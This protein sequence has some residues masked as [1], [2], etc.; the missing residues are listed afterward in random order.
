LRIFS[1]R[2][3]ILEESSL[4]TEKMS[5]KTESAYCSLR[6]R[7]SELLIFVSA[8]AY[9]PTLLPLGVSIVVAVSVVGSVGRR[10]GGDGLCRSSAAVGGIVMG[11]SGAGHP[12]HVAGIVHG[13]SGYNEQK[14]LDLVDSQ[15][16]E[17]VRVHEKNMRDIRAQRA[18]H[19][20]AL[21]N[22][23]R[24]EKRRLHWPQ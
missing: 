14:F 21:D 20:K 15:D 13:D 5:C 16:A 12:R 8:I 24:I 11:R 7:Q 17:I 3:W 4:F 19:L 10:V 2:N 23:Q 22:R 9:R 6:D 18:A 1:W